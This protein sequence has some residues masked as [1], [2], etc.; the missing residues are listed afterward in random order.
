MIRKITYVVILA[1]VIALSAQAKSGIIDPARFTMSDVKVEKVGEEVEVTFDLQADRVS[2]NGFSV[3]YAPVITD[4]TNVVSLTP[5]VVRNS[6][7]AHSWERHEWAA[8]MNPEPEG[9]LHMRNRDNLSYKSV[10]NFQPWMYNADVVAEL[11]AAGCCSVETYGNITIA[12]D[13]I[14]YEPEPEPVPTTVRVAVPAPATTGEELA[15]SRPYVVPSAGWD[16]DSWGERYEGDQEYALNI[17]FKTSISVIDRFYMDNGQT[18]DEIV[19]VINK[20][21]NSSDSRVVGV[22]V[23]GFASPDGSFAYNDKL[24][25]NR[26]VAVKEYIV[27]ATDVKASDVIVQ[28][29]SVDWYGLRRLVAED[30]NMPNREKVLKIINDNPVV[31]SRTNAKRLNL[32][33]NQDRTTYRYMLDNTFPELRR[34]SYI[35]IFFENK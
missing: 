3:I 25:W 10:V 23:A 5:V 15:K 22:V 14:G 30:S 13:I 31:D 27:K 29:G 4:G 6:R 34:G 16:R 26:A 20:I 19:S 9:T 32:L 35:R 11:S 8:D 1:A 28:N 12:S 24:A 18:L 21:N 17:Y 2:R 7:A 33:R